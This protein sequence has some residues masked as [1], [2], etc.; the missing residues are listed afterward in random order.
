MSTRSLHGFCYIF[1][2]Q[3]LEGS[4]PIGLSS[5]SSDDLNSLKVSGSYVYNSVLSFTAG[6]FNIWGNADPLLFADS[7]SPSNLG[8][9]NSNGE[10]F[11]VAWLPWS[12]GGPS[13][14]PWFNARL[15]VSYTLYN[16][17]NGASPTT[18]VLSAMPATTTQRLSTLGWLSRPCSPQMSGPPSPALASGRK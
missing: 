2:H 3:K 17:F 5:N 6:Y 18:M 11:D 16:Q 1:E 4:Q 13:F 12:K 14:Y 7:L 8:S 9:P 15:G 10:I